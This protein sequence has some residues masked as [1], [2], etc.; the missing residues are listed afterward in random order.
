M[1]SMARGTSAVGTVEYQ[2][3]FAVGFVLFVM[4]LV[5]NLLNDWFKRSFREEYQ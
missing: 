3:L 4:T 5:M 2:S 1:V